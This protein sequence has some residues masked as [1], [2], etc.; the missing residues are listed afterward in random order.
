MNPEFYVGFCCTT[1]CHLK[2]TEY[3]NDAINRKHISPYFYNFIH[4]NFSMKPVLKTMKYST[5]IC[6]SRMF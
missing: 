1:N 4:I 3:E 6:Y 2:H 5:T